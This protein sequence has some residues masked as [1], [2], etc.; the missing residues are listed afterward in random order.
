MKFSIFV[1]NR[2]LNIF[3]ILLFITSTLSVD[4]KLTS[5]VS[6]YKTLFILFYILSLSFIVYEILRKIYD[7]QKLKLLNKSREKEFKNV[8]NNFNLDKKYII[9]LFLDKKT[10]EFALDPRN[11]TIQILETKKILINTSKIDGNK[12][13]FQIHPNI[14]ESLRN[15]PNVLY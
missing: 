9:S 1:F 12:K 15:N 14:Y 3:L 11:P 13:I 2:I 10:T 5:F 8:L 4:E 6:I 7:A